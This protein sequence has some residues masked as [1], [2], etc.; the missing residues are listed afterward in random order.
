VL[1]AIAGNLAIAISKFVAAAATSSSA[2]LSEAI[3]SL[4]DAGN[5]GLLLYGMRR[6]KRPAD[7][8]HPFGHG[9]ELYFWSLVVAFSIFAVGGGVSIYEGIIHI[10]HPVPMENAVWNYAVLGASVVFEGITWYFGWLAFAKTRRGQPV[11]EAIRASKDPTSF[12][13]LLEDSASGTDLAPERLLLDSMDCIE[14]YL[15]RLLRG[16]QHRSQ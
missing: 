13:V 15:F 10:L 11:L 8:A 5:G 12:T 9:H 3:H 16:C 4:V 14:V 2:M 6:S 7:A 1:A